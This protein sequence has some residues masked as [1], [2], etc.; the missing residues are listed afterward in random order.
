MHKTKKHKI[1]I[2]ITCVIVLV[3]A[4]IA[5]I[6][7]I[8]RKKF[9]ITNETFQYNNHTKM[10]VDRMDSNLTIS[11]GAG[12]NS[13]NPEYYSNGTVMVNRKET[14]GYGIYSF[15]QGR[16]IIPT[17]YNT[18]NLQPLQL[19]NS[20][21]QEIDEYLF[22]VGS[23]IASTETIM[24]YYTDEGKLLDIV[25]YEPVTQKNYVKIKEKSLTL[26]EKRKGISVKTKNKFT[27]KAVAVS[28]VQYITSYVGDGYNYEVW[29]MTALDGTI[30]ENLY[31]VQED[32]NRKLLQTINN[33]I[34]LDFDSSEIEIS[35]LNDGSIRLLTTTIVEESS[36]QT[37][38]KLGVYDVNFKEKGTFN[39]TFNNNTLSIFGIGNSLFVQSRT[40]ATE[41]KY[42]Y[43]ELNENG[44]YNYYKLNTIQ[45]DFYSGDCD[46][47]DCDFIVNT[48]ST[49]SLKDCL[50]ASVNF[51]DNKILG[52]G[53]NIIINED[54]KTKEIDYT[55]TSV[56]KIAKD[57]YIVENDYGF[58]LIDEDFNVISNLG[59]YDSYFTTKESIILT[60]DTTQQTFVVD[61]DGT[62][63][64]RVAKGQIT[65]IYDDT[66]YMIEV[67][68]NDG[69]I[70]YYAERLGVRKHLL[71]QQNNTLD[72]P[73]QHTF[74]NIN[75]VRGGFDILSDNLSIITRV[76][77]SENNTFAYDFY[78][79]DGDLLLTL[80]GF[81][82]STRLLTYW[83]YS[84]DNHCIV[85]ISTNVGGEEYF[86]V[87]DK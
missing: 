14:V 47:V 59:D 17:N 70:K 75:Y 84:D 81:T 34:G 80:T 11:N 1:I 50:M 71:Y 20:H 33:G 58:L 2:A 3:V 41:N 23:P 19:T 10:V 6:L 5:S 60:N 30:Y 39:I 43:A 63:V 21:N 78:N 52:N 16:L 76:R 68:E 74:N 65:N 7:I 45:Y 37:V 48:S 18:G 57:R 4:I 27:N 82:T 55:I 40:L 26:E 25:S 13:T 32:G 67:E 9:D 38:A 64:K 61:L 72:N 35:I 79:V 29:K 66:Y 22:Y 53:K 51:I 44:L 8:T 83:D 86:M 49:T 24:S 15:V 62:I 77:E 12:S 69:T 46:E 42:D 73:T 56:I 54:L 36:L 28:S 31:E 85:Q 87:I